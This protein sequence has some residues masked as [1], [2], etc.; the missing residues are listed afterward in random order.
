MKP[1]KPKA[2]QSKLNP[3]IEFL[4]QS[5]PQSDAMLSSAELK[6]YKNEPSI[7]A[8]E[9]LEQLFRQA[10]GLPRLPQPNDYTIAPAAPTYKPVAG[11]DP[12]AML[13]YAW[14]VCKHV[15]NLNSLIELH[16]KHLLPV[17]R[18]RFNW[19]ILKSPHPFFSQDEQKILSTLDVGK[20]SGRNLDKYSKWPPHGKTT[21][22]P[23][24]GADVET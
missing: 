14:L 22:P 19:P 21:P 24:V 11:G 23:P 17:S 7:K 12:D 2:A 18:K 8:A 5:V 4:K 9:A 1:Q 10:Q 16:Q 15:E 3:A 13:E 20:K 6:K